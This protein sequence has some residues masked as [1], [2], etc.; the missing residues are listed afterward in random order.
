[1]DNKNVQLQRQVG[2]LRR[3]VASLKKAGS[4]NRLKLVERSTNDMTAKDFENL[5]ICFFKD[6]KNKTT[7][8][9]YQIKGKLFKIEGTEI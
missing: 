7:G 5:G 1:M 6:N 8:I 4:G 9:V 3:Q 2:V